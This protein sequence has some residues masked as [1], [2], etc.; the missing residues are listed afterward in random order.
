MYPEL[1]EIPGAR[2]ER[3]VA[4]RHVGAIAALAG[5]ADAIR[6]LGVPP[7]VE[8]Q[9]AAARR[10]EQHWERFGFGRWAIV[11]GDGSPVGWAGAF[12]P[13]WHPRLQDAVELGWALVGSARGRGLATAGAR[14][15]ITAAFELLRVDEVL[16]FV[17]PTNLASRAVAERAGLEP[18]GVDEDPGSGE[19]LDVFAARND[20]R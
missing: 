15:A 19:P 14:K 5:D 1:V 11:L 20:A 18:V 13:L 17:H 10:N 3:W 4:E 16:T 2:L 8:G 6:Y 7:T 9:M 12:H